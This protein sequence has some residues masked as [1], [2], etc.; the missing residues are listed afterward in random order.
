MPPG[1]ARLKRRQFLFSAG[2]LLATAH[3]SFAQQP[4]KGVPRVGFLGAATEA[5]YAARISALREGFRAL[6]YEEGRNLV[7]E[8][9]W[10]EGRYE[11]LPDLAA[12]LVR[13]KPDVIVTHAGPPTLAAKRATA[14]NP[15]P[16]VMTNVGDA[17]ANGIVTDLARPGGNITGDTFFLPEFVAKRIELLKEAV[18]EVRRLGVVA[19]PSNPL[20]A[21]YLETAHSVARS[22]RVTSQGFEMRDARD[23]DGIFASMTAKRVEAVALIEDANIIA[24]FGRIAGLAL[25]RRWP[26]IGFVDYADA[27]GLLGY[28]MDYLALYRRVAVFVDKILKG[29]RPGDIP[30]ERPTR[31]EFAINM[32]T[33]KALAFTAPEATRLRLT[34]A[35][36]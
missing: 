34:R 5:G 26:S 28:G 15:I 19:N 20:T 33:A 23:L 24:N 21:Q 12:D 7:I 2:A 6:G 3:R 27:G 31:F 1:I 13:S 25:Q 10:A 17:V 29:A 32:K 11:R 8:F 36:E 4:V 14:A 18:P 16:I 9:R 35:I 22:L 30:I